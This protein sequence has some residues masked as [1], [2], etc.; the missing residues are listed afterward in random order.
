M[1]EKLAARM[2]DKHICP[3]VT[4]NVPHAGGPILPPCC[5][6][7]FIQSLNAARVGDS[8]LCV[9]TPPA[10][11]VKGSTTVYIGGSLAA[12]LGDKTAHGGAISTGCTSVFIGD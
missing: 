1:P 8:A 12:R 6:T 2:T 9:S 7:V 11:I 10:T 4:A 3:A 5:K